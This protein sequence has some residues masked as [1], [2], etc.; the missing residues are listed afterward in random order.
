M[1]SDVKI[2]VLKRLELEDIWKKY[3]KPDYQPLCPL[4]KD[5]QEFVS[6]NLGM[7]EGFC[8]WAWTDIQK[9]SLILALGG[10]FDTVEE[11]GVVVACCTDGF[12]PVIFKLERV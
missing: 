10:N 9:F 4:V 1:R 8:D 7:P 5:G 2:T 11:E 12:R 3:K 6:K